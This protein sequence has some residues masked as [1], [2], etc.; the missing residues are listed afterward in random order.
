[1]RLTF[2]S[3][4]KNPVNRLWQIQLSMFTMNVIDITNPVVYYKSRWH[5]PFI[6]PCEQLYPESLPAIEQSDLFGFL[7]LQT[8]YYTNYQFKKYTSLE[9]YNQVVSGFMALLRG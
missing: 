2:R 7:V 3:V 1:M 8:S 6:I 9:T 5:N 4:I